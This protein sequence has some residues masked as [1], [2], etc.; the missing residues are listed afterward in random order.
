VLKVFPRL[1]CQPII[2]E[3]IARWMD[4]DG[5]ARDLIFVIRR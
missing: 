4:S 5:D 3:V 2:L 1:V